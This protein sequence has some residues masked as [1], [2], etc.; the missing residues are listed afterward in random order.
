[1]MELLIR[2]IVVN[3]SLYVYACVCGN[4]SKCYLVY[5][6]YT[7]ILFADYM[8]VKLRE[9]KRSTN[10]SQMLPEYK[11]REQYVTFSGAK[12]DLTIPFSHKKE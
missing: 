12:T 6:K 8:S 7:Q 9:K 10:F 2:L 5:F 1:M 11:R 4:I 3:I